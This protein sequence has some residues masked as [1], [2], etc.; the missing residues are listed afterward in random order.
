MVQAAS[1]DWRQEKHVLHV[2][3]KLQMRIL[4]LQDQ[5]TTIASGETNVDTGQTGHGST[6]QGLSLL[7][8][9]S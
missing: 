4:L 7:R 8:A 2:S 3:H 6:V 1:P 9:E 5:D